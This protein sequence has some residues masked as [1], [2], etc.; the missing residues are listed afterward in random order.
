MLRDSMALLGQT[1]LSLPGRSAHA[2]EKHDQLVA[3]IERHDAATAEEASRLHIRAAH[4]AR[5]ELMFEQE[6]DKSPNN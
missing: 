1:T 4:R 3:A 5:M 6:V 2:F